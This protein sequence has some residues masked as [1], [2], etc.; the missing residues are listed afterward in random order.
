MGKT[1][2]AI[3][4]AALLT[5]CQSS[6]RHAATQSSQDYDYSKVKIPAKYEGLDFS[7]F[8]YGYKCGYEMGR[9]GQEASFPFH[10]MKNEKAVM[11]GFYAGQYD[12]LKGND[13]N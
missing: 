2:I 6:G 5:S 13:P 4:F 12:G 8:L 7:S 1:L 11:A 10:G 3:V 9:K